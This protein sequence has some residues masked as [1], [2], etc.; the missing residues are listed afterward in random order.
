MIMDIGPNSMVLF[1]IYIRIYS[2]LDQ[3]LALLGI[4]C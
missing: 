3:R 1:V 2:K 4:K